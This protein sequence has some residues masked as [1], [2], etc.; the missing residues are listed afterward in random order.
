MCAP[1]CCV[2]APS[3]RAGAAGVA[4]GAVAPANAQIVAGTKK[5]TPKKVGADRMPA[6]NF[7]PVV[8]TRVFF[9]L[10]SMHVLRAYICLQ[11]LLCRAKENDLLRVRTVHLLAFCACELCA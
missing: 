5:P 3:A 4:F 8:S 11:S 9:R 1:P 6:K 7:A 2:L 10:L